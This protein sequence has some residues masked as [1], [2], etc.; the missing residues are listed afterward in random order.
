M[1]PLYPPVQIVPA[2]NTDPS[3]GTQPHPQPGAQ[4]T[5]SDPREDPLYLY[6]AMRGN[7][8]P[9]I[10][11]SADKLGVRKPDSP[12]MKYDGPGLSTVSPKSP[13]G[14]WQGMSVAPGSWSL[15]LRPETLHRVPQAL[16]GSSKHNKIW[17]IFKPNSTGNP[18][19]QYIEDKPGVHGLVAPKKCMEYNDYKRALESTLGQWFP[20]DSAIY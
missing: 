10:G 9:D 13:S 6:R 20:Y 18:T 8:R 17:K 1:S 3:P 2:P 4:E 19:L 14:E 15:L 5:R 7:V 12:D 11:E 16:G